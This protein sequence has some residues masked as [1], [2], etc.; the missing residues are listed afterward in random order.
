MKREPAMTEDEQLW[1]AFTKDVEKLDNDNYVIAPKKSNESVTPK[2]RSIPK[3]ISNE[4]AWIEPK[5]NCKVEK[6][7]DRS[8]EYQGRL[9]LHGMTLQVAHD[10]ALQ[11]LNECHS[12]GDRRVLIITGHGDGETSIK[13]EFPHWINRLHFVSE[14]MEAGRSQGGDGAYCVILRKDNTTS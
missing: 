5:K 6:K 10:R 3:P 7:K 11:F 14:Y 1:K 4:N 12:R 13:K 8:F 2:R 9:D